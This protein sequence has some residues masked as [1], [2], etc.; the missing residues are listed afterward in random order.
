MDIKTSETIGVVRN[1]IRRVELSIRTEMG[2]LRDEL[3]RHVDVVA[4]N[5]RDDIRII[6]EGL[7]A[8]EAKVDR[9]RPPD[10]LP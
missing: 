8:L 6:A 4:A 1:D 3:K 5:L 2:H 10:S 7:I 9:L